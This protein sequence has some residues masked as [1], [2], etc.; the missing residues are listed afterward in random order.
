VIGQPLQRLVG[1][2]KRQRGDAGGQTRQEAMVAERTLRD[3]GQ[4]AG[5]RLAIG[6]GDIQQLRGE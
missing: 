6:L 3:A 2:A 1:T 5:F 4:L